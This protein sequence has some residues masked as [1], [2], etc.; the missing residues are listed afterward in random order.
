MEM[1]G[2]SPGV[3]I[4][5]LVAAI[6]INLLLFAYIPH[7]STEPPPVPAKVPRQCVRFSPQMPEQPS[8]QPESPRQRTPAPQAP[9]LTP[10]APAVQQVVPAPASVRPNLALAI[11]PTIAPVPSQLAAAEAEHQPLNIQ[12]PP[13]VFAPGDLDMQPQLGHQNPPQ[14]PLQARRRGLSGYVKIEFDVLPDGAVR[15]L[16]I[17]ESSPPGVFDQAVLT[18]A[19]SWQYRAGELLGDRVRTRMVKKVVFNLEEQQ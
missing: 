5:G 6:G 4:V 1:R 13:A 18:A 8:V 7:S 10:V 9:P 3:F 15:R 11:V 16:R 19:E 17:L 12:S 14:Y 2:Q